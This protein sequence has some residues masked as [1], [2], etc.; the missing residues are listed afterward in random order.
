MKTT[1]GEYVVGAY[2]KQCLGCDVIDYNVRPPDD[3]LKGLAEFDVVGL[4]FKDKRAYICEVV[5]HLDGIKY[6]NNA[7]TIERIKKKHERQRDYAR[8]HLSDFEP[9][10]MLWSPV[11]PV[12][13]LTE[14]LGAIKTL[15]L[16]INGTYSECI[17][18]LRD[19]ARSTTR[20]AGNPF[21][22]AL[23]ILEH[24]REGT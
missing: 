2:L 10:F 13:Y 19:Q 5:T 1:M 7:T 14:Y 22:R 18:E 17:D 24:L 9:V 20:D 23:Q 6:G 15:E 11:V 12:G 3:G 4:R 21:F 8:E 16:C